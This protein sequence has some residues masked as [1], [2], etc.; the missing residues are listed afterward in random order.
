MEDIFK[1]TNTII[2]PELNDFYSNSFLVKG[3]PANDNVMPAPQIGGEDDDKNKVKALINKLNTVSDVSSSSISNI[4]S[5]YTDPLADAKIFAFNPT[6]KGLNW[7]RYKS[8]SSFDELGFDP[9]RDNDKFYNDNSSIWSDVTRGIKGFGRNALGM[10]WN[11]VTDLPKL[12]SGDWSPNTEA[13]KDTERIMSET[14]STRGT[15]GSSVINFGINAGFTVGII[16]EMIAEELLLAAVGLGGAAE[17]GGSSLGAAGYLMTVKAGIAGTKIMGLGKTL[18]AL[19]KSIRHLDDVSAAKTYFNQFGRGAVEFLNPLQA[20]T[21][22]AKNWKNLNGLGQVARASK[23]FGAFFKDIRDINRSFSEAKLE[24]GFVQNAMFENLLNEAYANGKTPTPED[25]DAIKE[26]SLHAGYVNQMINF[27]VIQYTNNISFGNLTRPLNRLIGSTEDT[28]KLLGKSISG[29]LTRKEVFKVMGDG[30]SESLKRNLNPRLMG[31][32]TLNYFSANLAEGLQ[33]SFQEASSI[34]VEDYYTKQFYNEN[35]IVKNQ[36]E[37]SMLD[38]YGKGIG[39]Q[40]SGQGAET[41]LSGFLMGGLMHKSVSG[42]KGAI[43]GLNESSNKVKDFFYSRTKPEA[44]KEAKEKR[45][46][47]KSQRETQEKEY[48]DLRNKLIT[49][50]NEFY[51]DAGN[52]LTPDLANMSAQEIL[53]AKGKQA[54]ENGDDKFLIDFTDEA[55]LESVSTA[56]YTGKYDM[57]IEHLEKMKS[58]DDKSLGEALG[59]TDIEAGRQRLEVSIER[60]KNIKQRSEK[61]AENPFKIN[62][63]KKGTDEYNEMVLMHHAYEGAKKL[64]IFTP[65]QFDRVLSRMSSITDAF[66]NIDLVANGNSA[67]FLHLFGADNM[68][69][70]VKILDQEI[71]SLKDGNKD[72][73]RLAKQKEN[74]IQDL[75]DIQKAIAEHKKYYKEIKEED[76]VDPKYDKNLK[77]AFIKYLGT[78]GENKSR[79]LKSDKLEEAF[80]LF[81]DYYRLNIDAEYLSR[82][83]AIVADPDFLRRDSLR[84]YETLKKNHTNRKELIKKSVD[85]YLKKIGLN[86]VFQKLYDA[87]F[88]GEPKEMVAY[89]ISGGKKDV[90]TFYRVK[91]LS[92]VNATDVDDIAKI[93]EIFKEYEDITGVTKEKEAAAKKAREDA[94]KKVEE[95]VEAARVAEKEKALDVYTPETKAKLVADY[96]V[97]PQKNTQSFEEYL[98]TP[99]AARIIAAEVKPAPVPAPIITPAPTTS[100]STSDIETKKAELEAAI[101]KQEE[102]LIKITIG[103]PIG[104]IEGIKVGSRVISGINADIIDEFDTDFDPNIAENDGDGYS[105]VTR[106]QEYGESKDGKLTKRP[107]LFVITFNN[108]TDADAYIEKRKTKVEEYKSKLGTGIAIDRFKEELIA[109]ESKPKTTSDI[110]TKKADI[111]RRR[112]EELL[113]FLPTGL[114]SLLNKIVKIFVDKSLKNTASY[115]KITRNGVLSEDIVLSTSGNYRNLLHELIHKFIDGKFDTDARLKFRSRVTGLLNRISEL[116]E[117]SVVGRVLKAYTGVGYSIE[118][119]LVTWYLTDP[120][121]RNEIDSLEE[122]VK[123]RVVSLIK[124]ISGFTDS[125]IEEFISFDNSEKSQE[126]ASETIDKINAIFDAELESL[127]KKETPQTKVDTKDIKQTPEGKKIERRR[128]EDLEKT[129]AQLETIEKN[130]DSF[131]RVKV[132]VYTTLSNEETLNEVEIIT[133][134]DGSRRIRATDAKTG[135]IVLEEKIKKDNSTTNEKFIE[136]FI[137]NLDN[138]LKKISEDSNPNKTAI[139]KIN[140]KYDAELD[141]LGGKPTTPTFDIKEKRKEVRAAVQRAGQGEGGQFFVTLSD[142]T[143]ESAVRISLVGDE[144]GIGNKGASVDL[145][146]IDKIENPDGTVIYDANVPIAEPEI[147]LTQQIENAI[148]A[149]K[150]K[151]LID[152]STSSRELDKIMD[153]IDAVDQMTPDILTAINVKRDEFIAKTEAFEAQVIGEEEEPTKKELSDFQKESNNFTLEFNVTKSIKAYLDKRDNKWRFFNKKGKEVKSLNQILKYGKELIKKPN[154][155]RLWYTEIISDNSREA[156]KEYITD[157]YQYYEEGMENSNTTY[158]DLDT[159]IMFNLVNYKFRDSN[160]LSGNLTDVKLNKWIDNSRGSVHTIDNFAIFLKSELA[161]NGFPTYDEYDIINLVIDIIQRYP[162]GI[163]EKTYKEAA[164]DSAYNRRLLNLIDDFGLQFGLDLESVTEGLSNVITSFEEYEKDPFEFQGEPE[165]YE[166][167]SGYEE[168]VNEKEKQ[169]VK[170]EFPLDNMFKG[171]II[172]FSPGLGKTTLVELYPDQFVDMDVL[173]YEEFKNDPGFEN[174]T[175]E[176]IG[177]VVFSM[178][179]IKNPNFGALK[180]ARYASAFK[181]AQA[182]AAQGKTVLTGSVAFISSADYSIKASNE[183]ISKEAIRKKNP[184]ITDASL[185]SYLKSLKTKQDQNNLVL[186]VDQNSLVE[187]LTGNYDLLPFIDEVVSREQ[188]IELGKYITSK[189]SKEVMEAFDKKMTYLNA[190]NSLFS[191]LQPGDTVIILSEITG[192]QHKTKIVKMRDNDPNTYD[193]EYD[194]KESTFFKRSNLHNLISVIPAQS[195]TEAIK[196]DEVDNADAKNNIEKMN[197]SFT[198]EDFAQLDKTMNDTSDDDMINGSEDPTKCTK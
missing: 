81:N 67:E 1:D 72:D 3:N 103:T 98:E 161:E 46:E 138:S 25:I 107:K 150:W 188:L 176:N 143:R 79:I 42:F 31:K 33:E 119:E 13:A 174:A 157:L 129:N 100:T 55:L 69:N 198:E 171:K 182:L 88:V 116:S 22:L 2:T 82:S 151:S 43:T 145:G 49:N 96:E 91:D 78:Y 162:N 90:K 109:L 95:A 132:E 51:A 5:Q 165:S 156:V 39:A 40:F 172:Y 83:V 105:I 173:L 187:L 84:R 140:A 122:N 99:R 94:A 193:L 197:I 16:G 10:A 38:S 134:K 195:Q 85:T 189:Q 111:E 158:T 47:R 184:G 26:K 120:E 130:G 24:G 186:S 80:K 93:R 63:Y 159:L 127:K 110:E 61:F 196:I 166:D 155:L 37:L 52:M 169:K 77:N 18:G 121:F 131:I 92:Q 152:K 8:H 175:P 115:R 191:N 167:F 60:A 136:S 17:T 73:Q 14:M 76:E 58:L 154:L 190:R 20:T 114:K 137:G 97:Y 41:F 163:S 66:S 118:E 144:L 75:S 117:D 123:N 7:D 125:Q 44:F 126:K 70:E 113:S 54:L 34:A 160:E 64:A 106:I 177:E 6:Y 87:G 27:P 180:D 142:G 56:L 135:E 21:D 32:N 57:F 153:S 30:W 9:F 194:P 11:N 179:N 164:E 141:A 168:F 50:L 62:D 12:L 36:Y 101:K 185:K 35:S 133:F 45:E 71:Q 192:K 23:S 112:Q 15:F 53:A 181:K 86:G 108:K 128:Q 29:D 68:L 19:G 104:G 74:Q 89:N 183:D 139:D 147:S 149:D 28:F 102:D 124:E 4:Q 59:T 148:I 170:E 178:Y 146:I 65:Y 48:D